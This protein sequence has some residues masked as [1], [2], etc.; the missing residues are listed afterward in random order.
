MTPWMTLA[1]ACAYTKRSRE[2]VRRA[3]VAYQRNDRA[4]L[5]TFQPHPNA[6]HTFHVGD[7]DR[8]MQG[9]APARGP[10]RAYEAA[11]KGG[12]A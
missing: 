10:I 3:A 2:T 1:E 5:R 6:C 8:W 11:V 12:A 4:G 7:L 9:L